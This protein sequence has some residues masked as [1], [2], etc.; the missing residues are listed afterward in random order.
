M[1]LWIILHYTEQSEEEL[2]Q[3]RQILH[4]VGIRN[5]LIRGDHINTCEKL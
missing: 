3:Q 5:N 2:I 1:K 4:E